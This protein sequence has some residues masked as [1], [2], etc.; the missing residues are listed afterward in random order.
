MARVGGRALPVRDKIPMSGLLPHLM[1]TRKAYS[2][3]RGGAP[4]SLRLSR[5]HE[6]ELSPLSLKI[7]LT[8]ARWARESIQEFV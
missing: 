4:A 2:G 8:G 7:E 1:I 6:T 3:P 5:V